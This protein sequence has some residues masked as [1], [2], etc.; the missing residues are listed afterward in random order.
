MCRIFMSDPDA[1]REFMSSLPGIKWQKMF[2]N[3]LLEHA[4]TDIIMA[5]KDEL[6][7]L[8]R[9]DDEELTSSVTQLLMRLKD[10]QI[11]PHL[12]RIAESGAEAKSRAMAS[13][14]IGSYLQEGI[15]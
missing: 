8:L 6:V 7:E 10:P 14:I 4:R 15:I 1:V 5:V 12:I 13:S 11:V 2:V 3:K 9:S